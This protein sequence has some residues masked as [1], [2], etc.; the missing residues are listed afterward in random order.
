MGTAMTYRPELDPHTTERLLTGSV[1]PDDAPP[2]FAAV[3]ALLA[4]LR[5]D[6]E[7]VG[8]DAGLDALVA[9]VRTQPDRPGRL[10]PRRRPMLTHLVA[11]KVAVVVSAVALGVGGAAAA[12]ALPAS[13]QNTAHSMLDQVGVTVPG[14]GSITPDHPAANDS[15]SQDNTASDP[16]CDAATVTSPPSVTTASAD[17]QCND[18]PPVAT[19]TDEHG[20]SQADQPGDNQSGNNQ[21]GDTE[22]HD[23]QTGQVDQPSANHTSDNESGDTEDHQDAG[24]EPS[25]STPSTPTTPTDP[26][27]SGDHGGGSSSHGHD[28]QGGGNQ[29]SGD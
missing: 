24:N 20:T 12:G 19:E 4:E 9:A 18:A 23:H 29:S 15:G 27:S 13:A 14:G 11:A 6:P 5:S 25:D 16:T 2:G 28:N 3:A 21:S 8:T 7:A 26:G 10:N 17:Q 22:S 1:A